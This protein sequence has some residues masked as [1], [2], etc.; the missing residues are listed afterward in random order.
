LFAGFYVRAGHP[1]A[2][3][4]RASP[5]DLVTFGLATVKLPKSVLDILSQL[6]VLEPGSPLPLSLE[7]D[8][9]P[10]LKRAVLESDTILA[11]VQA[12]VSDEVTSGE[13]V[14]LVVLGTPPLYSDLGVVSLRGRSHSPMAAT[15]IDRLRALVDRFAAMNPA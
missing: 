14:P 9:V 3:T 11:A 2:G 4:Q 12:A 5:A 15:V 1:L 6:M 8:D 10:T 7:S 13:L